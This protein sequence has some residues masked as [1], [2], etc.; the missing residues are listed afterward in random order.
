[1][2]AED[3]TI[4]FVTAG[5]LAVGSLCIA[6]G[7]LRESGLAR[8]MALIGAIPAASMAIG[9]LLMGME[10]A[11]FATEGREQSV[12][13]FFAY[14]GALVAFGYLLQQSVFL[15]RRQ[16]ALLVFV[17]VSTPWTQFFTWFLTGTVESIVTLLSLSLF[18]FASYLML[19][20]YSKHAADIG[21]RRELLYAKLRNLF[22]IGYVTLIVTSVASEQVLGLLT[23]FVATIAAGY[24]DGVVMLGI[25]LLVL[26][27]ASAFNDSVIEQQVN[28]D[29]SGVVTGSPE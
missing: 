17:L 4:Y 27:S 18:I 5:V 9:Y 24:A 26:S 1:M 25:G 11:T 29:D 23:T 10:V 21:G 19:V 14:T 6:G 20:P 22:V 16:T 13:R 2:V 8:R 7:A 28:P 3:T 12:M 15:S